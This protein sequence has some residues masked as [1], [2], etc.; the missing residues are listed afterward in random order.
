M[1]ADQDLLP[2]LPKALVVSDML[3]LYRHL[4]ADDQ[5]SVRLLT[6]QDLVTIAGMLD[7]AE[8]RQ[9]LLGSI[10]SAFQDLS[11]IHI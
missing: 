9:Q 5:D 7:T 10:H 6:V 8:V 3:P 1:H 4:S 2:H 11:L